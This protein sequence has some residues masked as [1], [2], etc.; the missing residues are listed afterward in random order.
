MRVLFMN[1]MKASGWRGGEKWM[2][3]AAAGLAS[4]GHEVHLAVRPGSVMAR[5]AS[6]RGVELFP[7]SYGADLDP[8]NALRVRRFLS[9][10]RIELVCTNFEKEN[11]LLA[12]AGLGGPKPVIVARKGLPYIFDKWR[13]RI[14]YKRWVKHIVTPSRSI[15]RRFREYRWLDHVGITVIPNGVRVED[16]SG[17]EPAGLRRLHGV[18]EDVPLLG[19]VGDLARQKGVDLLLE[20]VSGIGGPWRLFIVG[21]GGERARLEALSAELGIR[22]RTVFTGYSDDVPAVL[23]EMD[24]VACPSLFEGMPN[25]LLEAMASGRAVVASEVDGIEEV[26]TGPELGSLVPAGDVCALRGAIEGLLRD[27]ARRSAMG[28]AARRHVAE[29]FS[30]ETMVSRLEDL[31]ARLL[32]GTPRA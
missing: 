29:R 20:A 28:E 1:S 9:R 11:R 15:E 27:P 24:L 2:V 8:L 14:I 12:L 23:R 32:E 3:E 6:R 10:K 18:P 13:Y 7:L 22:E 30:T 16:Y 26:L 17:A 19:F 25:V 21:D 31:F 4:R 5:K